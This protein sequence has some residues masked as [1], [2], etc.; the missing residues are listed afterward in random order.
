MGH[1]D[2]PRQVHRLLGLRHGLLRGEQHPDGGRGGGSPRPRDDLDP[3]RALLG[4][5]RGTAKPRRARFVPMLCQHCAN[6]PCEPVCPVYAAYHTADGLNGQVYNRCVGTRYCANNCPYKVRYFNWYKYNEQAW[7]E[8]LNLQLNPDVTVRARGVMEKCTFCIQRIRG[9]QHQARLEDRPIRD[10]EFTTACAQACPSDAIVFGNV[11][12]PESRV[13]KRQ[14]GPA[15]LPRPRGAQRATGDHVPGQGRAS[16]GGGLSHG[17]RRASRDPRRA[18]DHPDPRRRHPRRRR[19]RSRPP[20]AAT[21]CCCSA[22]WGCSWSG[23]LTFL[24]LIKDGL[25]HAGYTAAD[26]LERLHHHLRVLDRHRT[27]GH[28]D[29]GDPLPVPLALAHGGLPLHRGDDGVRGHDRGAVPDHPHRA[30]VDLLLAAAVPEPALLW[31]NF[32]S[33]LVWDVFAISTYLTVSTTFLVVGLIPDVAA[34][35]DKASG[36]RQTGLQALLG[37]A[38]RAPTTSGATTPAATSTSPR[39]RRR[40]C[41]RCTRWCPGTSRRPS[42]PAGTARSSRRTS[43]PAPSTRA[44]AWCSR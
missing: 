15:R 37:W 8:P 26:L 28:A 19:R 12:D 14:A 32:K 41:S 38:G 18:R 31:P 13:A 44:S 10:G 40:W 1:G 24:M 7:P 21:S 3:H 20:A 43:W 9:A 11:R 17:H 4:R 6:A 5:W 36:W 27:R 29:L 33:P 2:R 22:P 34:V 16:G 35:R 39:S 42:S 25:G 30:A 23:L